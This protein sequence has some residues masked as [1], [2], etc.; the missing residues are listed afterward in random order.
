MEGIRHM[1]RSE[2]E[3]LPGYELF[4]RAHDAYST[5]SSIVM[6]AFAA[7]AIVFAF[8]L[9]AVEHSNL[10]LDS[11][12]PGEGQEQTGFVQ[13]A[14]RGPVLI[15]C[16]FGML[17]TLV[18]LRALSPRENMNPEAARLKQPT[19]IDLSRVVYALAGFTIAGLV[20]WAVLK[21]PSSEQW[22]ISGPGAQGE[23]AGTDGDRGSR[24][25][26]RAIVFTLAGI[27]LVSFAVTNLKGSLRADSVGFGSSG[28]LSMILLT[29]LAAYGSCYVLRVAYDTVSN[30]EEV[31][32]WGKGARAVVYALLASVVLVLMSLALL[33]FDR[34]FAWVQATELYKRT[35]GLQ[36]GDGSFAHG[37]SQ[38]PL[39][40]MS[41]KAIARTR[42]ALSAVML[43]LVAV[44]AILVWTSSGSGSSSGS[45]GGGE[46]GTSVAKGWRNVFVAFSATAVMLPL[47]TAAALELWYIVPSIYTLFSN[48]MIALA[49][50][51]VAMRYVPWN[52]YTV[53]AGVVLWAALLLQFISTSRVESNLQLALIFAGSFVLIKA[54]GR[55]VYARL[56]DNLGEGEEVARPIA[57]VLWMIPALLLGLLWMVRGYR[58]GRGFQAS[59]VFIAF[60]VIY[61]VAFFDPKR[62]LGLAPEGSATEGDGEGRGRDSSANGGFLPGSGVWANVGVDFVVITTLAMLVTAFSSFGEHSVV[63]IQEYVVQQRTPVTSSAMLFAVFVMVAFVVSYLYNMMQTSGVTRDFLGD[64][65]SRARALAAQFRS[66]WN[67]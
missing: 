62:D 22:S 46:D 18:V 39:S 35:A 1:S 29:V 54:T 49:F 57:T 41:L 30:R 64:L 53:L 47:V 48:M 67:S 9:I 10:N 3:A 19:P 2:R 4:L 37:P 56:Q 31:A 33:V 59:L 43:L 7:L 42:Q 21:G 17:F 13:S 24:T 40:A 32:Q 44:P 66:D 61:G 8:V 38:G 27:A 65:Q 45:N 12:T 36:Q 5:Q 52:E 15:P 34:I 16:A 51:L 6:V 26:D 63:A 20:L 55:L 58:A 11:E 60:V 50:F 25:T 14:L 23:G 28:V